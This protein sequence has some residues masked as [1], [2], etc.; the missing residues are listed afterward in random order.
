M[1]YT[2]PSIYPLPRSLFVTPLIYPPV[3]CLEVAHDDVR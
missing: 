2:P 1:G 3:P